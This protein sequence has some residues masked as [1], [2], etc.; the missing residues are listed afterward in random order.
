MA[1]A[2]EMILLVGLLNMQP[3]VIQFMCPSVQHVTANDVYDCGDGFSQFAHGC[4]CSPWGVPESAVLPL[5]Y[6]VFFSSILA[7]SL[8][9]W[10][11]Q[12]TAASNVLGYTAIQP[13]TS[14]LLTVVLM[15]L[16][17]GLPLQM[18]GYNLLGGIGILLGV[19]TLVLANK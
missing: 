14:A 9:T 3:A 4:S 2:V 8:V 18:P 16:I 12:Y 7:Y 1:A 19:Y 13:L 15:Q 10:T 17:N 5:L 11:N 6:W